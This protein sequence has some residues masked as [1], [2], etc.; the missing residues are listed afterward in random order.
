MVFTAVRG[1]RVSAIAEGDEHQGR[2]TRVQ[3]QYWIRTA[4]SLL[5]VALSVG[6]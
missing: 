3:L 6:E 2:S 4:G 5:L 1:A